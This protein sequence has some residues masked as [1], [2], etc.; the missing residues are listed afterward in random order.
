MA[1]TNQMDKAMDTMVLWPAAVQ[2]D[3]DHARMSHMS[4]FAGQ[5]DIQVP[6]PKLALWKVTKLL[7]PRLCPSELAT[8][9]MAA[10]VL[11][12]ERAKVEVQLA[13]HKAAEKHHLDS[14]HLAFGQNPQGLFAAKSIRK[15]IRLIPLGTV[16]KAKS[17]KETKLTIHHAGLSWTI[18]P[19]R[20]NL[21]FEE[22]SPA[23]LVPY[24]WC[25]PTSEAD[26]ASMVFSS[27]VESGITIPCLENPEP[28]QQHQ[29]LQ[30]L[31]ATAEVSEEAQPEHAQASEASGPSE[32]KAKAKTKAKAKAKGKGTE[33][34]EDLGS[35]RAFK[36][37]LRA[38][39]AA[40]E[41]DQG[42]NGEL[43]TVI[44]QLLAEEP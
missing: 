7:M 6:L 21:H 2:V 13:L 15:T 27:I 19:F 23:C 26:E 25:K 4:L 29:Q 22:D 9:S 42:C 3:D 36:F 16:N 39:K 5:E 37:W 44:D 28:L 8:A 32:P 17:N 11:V 30:Y 31:A 34:S 40:V 14:D 1:A 38:Q 43:A 12:E 33:M 41:P 10:S 18:G 35:D 24:F 20:Q